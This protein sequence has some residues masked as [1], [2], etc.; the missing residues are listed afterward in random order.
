M[1][2]PILLMAGQEASVSRAEEGATALAREGQAKINLILMKI[3]RLAEVRTLRS[4]LRRGEYSSFR[5][6]TTQSQGP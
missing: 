6:Q 1:I 4:T 5:R 3:R 2:C